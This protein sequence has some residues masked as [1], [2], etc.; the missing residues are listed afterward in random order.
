MK[1]ATS[2]PLLTAKQARAAL[3]ARGETVTAFARRHGLNRSTV[4]QVLYGEKKGRYGES[5]RAAVALGIKAPPP[6]DA[7]GA[8]AL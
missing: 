3:R 8:G 6:D 4:Y 1:T 2:R 5:H 7:A